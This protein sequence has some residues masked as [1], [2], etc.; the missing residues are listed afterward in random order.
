MSVSMRFLLFFISVFLTVDANAS[1]KVSYD[2]A[3]ASVELTAQLYFYGPGADAKTVQVI[4]DEINLYWN[5][6][7]HLNP[8]LTPLSVT[9]DSHLVRFHVHVTGQ[10]L[11]RKAEKELKHHSRSPEDNFIKLFLRGGRSGMGLCSQEGTWYGSDQLG[12][13]TTAAHEFGHGLC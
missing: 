6:G 1:A 9:I 2:A 10:A 8:L 4:I 11:S 13:S 7:T 12:T 5:G 3:R